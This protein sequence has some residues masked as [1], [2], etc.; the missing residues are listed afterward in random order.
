MFVLTLYICD[1]SEELLIS[2]Y[3]SVIIVMVKENLS[4]IS[5]S[6]GFFH[7]VG[8]DFETFDHLVFV[9]IK[10]LLFRFNMNPTL[11][12]GISNGHYCD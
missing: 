4:L 11:S 1:Y 10:N 3:S 6:M 2:L 9:I 5:E 7:L 12:S 8:P